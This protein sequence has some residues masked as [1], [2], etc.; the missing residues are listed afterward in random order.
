VLLLAGLVMGF[1]FA[2]W[3]E[4]GGRITGILATIAGL[5]G[6]YVGLKVALKASQTESVASKWRD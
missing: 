6:A 1:N 2:E 3:T 4:T 5:V